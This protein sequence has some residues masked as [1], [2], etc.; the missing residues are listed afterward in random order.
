MSFLKKTQIINAIDI[1]TSAV[2]AVIVKQDE[3]KSL[4][5]IGIGQAVSNGLR[6][7]MIIDIED[8]V[9]AI[10]AAKEIAERAS[11]APIEQAYI[12]LSGD[13][14]IARQSKGTI[15]VSRADGEVSKEDLER[16]IDSAQAIP[17]T[18]NRE[19]LEVIPRTFSI[20]GQN[21]IKCPI[22][23]HGVRLEADVLLLEA[24]SPIIK[25]LTKSVSQAGIEILDLI[26]SP[27]ASAHSVLSKKQKELGTALIDL[28]AG[29]T[30]VIIF[31]EG[32]ILHLSIL[33]IGGASIT[34]DL[35]IGLKTSIETAEKVKKEY[36]KKDQIDLAKFSSGE[37]GIVSQDK[38][39]NII[40]ARV[41]E[42]FGM[43]NKELKK[44]GRQGLLP[45]G[46]VL[47]GAGAKMHNIIDLT[48]EYLSLPAQI[49]FPRSLAGLSDEVLD[50]S[51]ATAIGL[52]LCAVENNKESSKLRLFKTDGMM[53]KIKKWT[54]AFLP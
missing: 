8:T 32:D 24:S 23:M 22:G 50:P 51:F 19:I 21:H 34:N 2:R 54:R 33:P 47:V 35:A 39:S 45:G 3:G 40:E 48:K 53:A 1:G 25:N 27:I 43:I 9:K 6:R 29:T 13:H 20:D 49:G 4:K 17:L 37:E 18:L 12:N 42:I 44:I 46:V 38:I 26:P 36:H 30:G 31:E 10:N 52:V 16:V 28:G 7:G 41:S 11:G 14:I 15:V 5:I